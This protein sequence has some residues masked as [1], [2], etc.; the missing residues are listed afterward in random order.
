MLSHAPLGSLSPLPCTPQSPASRLLRRN[1]TSLTRHRSP[2]ITIV[3]DHT[4][5]PEIDAHHDYP[6]HHGPYEPLPSDSP[7]ATPS[8][9][10]SLPASVAAAIAA[11]RQGARAAVP[12]RMSDG[13]TAVAGRRPAAVQQGTAS[14]QATASGTGPGVGTGGR[15]LMSNGTTA[16]GLVGLQGAAGGMGLRMRRRVWH[17]SDSGVAGERVPLI[18]AGSTSESGLAGVV[19]AG[20]GEGGGQKGQGGAGRQ[21]GVGM[22]RRMRM[23]APGTPGA[24]GRGW[25]DMGGGPEYGRPRAGGRELA[26]AWD[27]DEGEE[28]EEEEGPDDMSP[29]RRRRAAF[30]RQWRDWFDD[31][32]AAAAA[33]AAAPATSRTTRGGGSGGGSGGD[34]L[35]SP[36]PG[37]APAFPPARNT[38]FDAQSVAV[39]LAL[40]RP[41]AA[42]VPASQ[43]SLSTAL[44]CA[45]YGQA[46]LT[47]MPGLDGLA[48]AAVGAGALIRV[49]SGSSALPSPSAAAGYRH[50]SPVQLAA[51]GGGGADDGGGALSD[52]DE[53]RSGFASP[54][55]AV[56]RWGQWEEGPATPDIG[57]AGASGPPAARQRS[58]SA[59]SATAALAI[60][61]EAPADGRG[62]RSAAAAAAPLGLRPGLG[63]VHGGGGSGGSSGSGRGGGHVHRSPRGGARSPRSPLSLAPARDSGQG[64]S[65]P[66]QQPAPSNPYPPHQHQHHT[67][68]QQQPPHA[69]LARGAPGPLGYSGPGQVVRGG[70]PRSWSTGRV[71]AH[72]HGH[73]HHH[74]PTRMRE[75]ATAA[76]AAAAS[77]AAGALAST[78]GAYGT[79]GAGGGV[80]AEER[81]MMAS[82]GGRVGGGGGTPRSQPT[83]GGEVLT[84]GAE[85]AGGTGEA[86]EGLHSAGTALDQEG[87]GARLPSAL[88][89]GPPPPPP[90][91]LPPPP[92]PLPSR[93]AVKAEE[94]G[95]GM[96]VAAAVAGWCGGAEAGAGLAPLSPSGCRYHAYCHQHHGSQQVDHHHQHHQHHGD[97]GDDG[98]ERR[99][100]EQEAWW[101]RPAGHDSEGRPYD[102]SFAVQ[103]AQGDGGSGGAMGRRLGEV[104]LAAAAATAAARGTRLH[105]RRQL[106][107]GAAGKPLAAAAGPVAEAPIASAAAMSAERRARIRAAVQAK[108]GEQAGEGWRRC[109]PAVGYVG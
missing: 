63:S 91:P 41:L 73:Q 48:A 30:V 11:V 19:G 98:A 60:G 25:S 105:Q 104:L 35:Q 24:M 108:K 10:L 62:R 51:G 52:P 37:S 83:L 72:P 27:G 7:R 96:K 102:G 71:P 47:L 1:H 43:M 67:H 76:A 5:D 14:Q 79:E 45:L 84:E 8:L 94:C 20:P 68:H 46:A 58:D 40:Q 6:H 82:G 36:A 86:A 53:L 4:P 90:A 44:K 99:Q 64:G 109:L 55:G 54:H 100:A 88:L 16:E 66:Y 80:G 18:R 22:R 15:G 49:G 28:V 12:W 9:R 103:P 85:A 17:R 29:Q 77:E 56:G 42:G 23:S 74:V 2:A 97:G 32:D 106:L 78:L 57:A 75:S 101:W 3:T 21:G 92:S 107:A 38:S 95:Q 31:V 61:A 33:A 93:P 89:P 70:L 34:A 50:V 39:G 69:A 59:E 65:T 87:R 81:G 26:C 13:G